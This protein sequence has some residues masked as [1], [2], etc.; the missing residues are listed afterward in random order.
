M[1]GSQPRHRPQPR[2]SQLVER[3]VEHCFQA[4]PTTGIHHTDRAGRLISSTRRLTA[5]IVH[6]TPTTRL[7]SPCTHLFPVTLTLST[8]LITNAPHTVI[9]T[10]I[11][12]TLQTT[13][14][15]TTVRG[16][17]RSVGEGV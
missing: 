2:T 10:V 11:V 3:P 15:T 13:M 9:H 17:A 5:T 12:L 6:L 4:D 8:T 7:P 1:S 16:L 14:S